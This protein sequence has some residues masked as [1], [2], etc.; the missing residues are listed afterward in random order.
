MEKHIFTLRTQVAECTL[1][2]LTNKSVGMN[3]N[4]T[5]HNDIAIIIWK[6]IKKY[7]EN[8]NISCFGMFIAVVSFFY[9]LLNLFDFTYKQYS[10]YLMTKNLKNKQYEQFEQKKIRLKEMFYLCFAVVS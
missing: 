5:M 3:F 7:N 10:L 6:S 8:L 1:F 2:Q 9:L 4:N